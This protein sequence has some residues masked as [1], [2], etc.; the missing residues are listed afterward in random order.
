MK[1]VATA[2]DMQNNFG[3][4]LG[5]VM[6]GS[7]VIV[8]RNGKEVARLISKGAYASYLTDA[9]TGIIASEESLTDARERALKVK[10]EITD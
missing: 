9:L 5:L 10:Y 4:Y 1:A 6:D 3:Y 8:T 7:E 2:T